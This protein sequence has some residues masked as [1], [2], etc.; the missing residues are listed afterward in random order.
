MAFERSPTWHAVC[1]T[2]GMTKTL[3]QLVLA[4]AIALTTIGC[5]ASMGLDRAPEPGQV[6]VVRR[7]DVSGEL[8]LRPTFAAHYAAEDAML[9]H[10]GGRVRFVSAAEAAELAIVDPSDPTKVDDLV[11]IDPHAE[12]LYYVCVT[13]AERAGLGTR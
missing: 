8:A 11:M 4:S 13:R 10:C 9:A 12:R 7:G 2:Q 1:S 3:L 5:G 6:R